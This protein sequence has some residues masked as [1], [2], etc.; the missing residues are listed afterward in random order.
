M[1]IKLLI[2]TNSFENFLIYFFY[3][4]FFALLSYYRFSTVLGPTGQVAS[5]LSSLTW[6]KDTVTSTGSFRHP[7]LAY[8][9][10]LPCY[11][12]GTQVYKLN[13]SGTQG[14]L[15]AKHRYPSSAKP[16][17]VYS[18]KSIKT[19]QFSLLTLTRL[20]RRF[21]SR[22]NFVISTVTSFEPLNFNTNI[23]KVKLP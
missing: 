19:N 16:S 4:T 14:R 8:D 13:R 6:K 12:L 1:Q 18:T 3:F 2:S 21:H 5:R 17:A 7:L 10:M 11:I 20:T 15:I 23:R 9:S 22:P